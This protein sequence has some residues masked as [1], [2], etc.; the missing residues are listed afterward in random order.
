[1]SITESLMKGC[2]LGLALGLIKRS[3]L[4]KLEKAVP[5]VKVARY[6]QIENKIRALVRYELASEI[7]LV[8]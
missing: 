7:P 3:Y 1:M 2:A 6:I 4:P 5:P 8:P